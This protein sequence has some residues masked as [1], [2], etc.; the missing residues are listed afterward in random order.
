MTAI[1][2]AYD[3]R[4]GR[5]TGTYIDRDGRER[6]LIRI[7]WDHV[8]VIL[9]HEYG[10]DWRQYDRAWDDDARLVA[11][12][13]A[14]GAPAWVVEA[15]GCAD[16]LGWGLVEP[17]IRIGCWID[18]HHG[19]HIGTIVMEI[20]QGYGWEGGILSPYDDGYDDAWDAAECWLNEHVAPEN[21][22]FGSDPDTGDWGLWP[23]DDEAYERSA[24]DEE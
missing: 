22:W 7:P 9:G 24:F 1:D 21:A 19:M 23:L 6:T 16:E 13:L 5:Y 20:A 11:W 2:C 15:E 17:T 4:M 3:L 14:H 18:S 8:A 10:A 12:L